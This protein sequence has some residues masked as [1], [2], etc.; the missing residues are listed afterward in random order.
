MSDSK[1]ALLILLAIVL[2]ALLF[3]ESYLAYE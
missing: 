1:A 3:S 2:F